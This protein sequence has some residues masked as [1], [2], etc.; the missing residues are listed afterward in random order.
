MS[1]GTQYGDADGYADGAA[2]YPPLISLTP[3][4]RGYEDDYTRAY[5]LAYARGKAEHTAGTS[6]PPETST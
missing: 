2:G 6:T 4:G 5:T 1:E 3:G